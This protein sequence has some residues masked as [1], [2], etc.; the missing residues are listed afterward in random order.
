MSDVEM[1]NVA[2]TRAESAD[3]QHSTSPSAVSHREKTQIYRDAGLSL[4]KV[5]L[6]SDALSKLAEIYKIQYGKTLNVKSIDPV[7][8]GDL[9]SCCINICYNQ[10]GTRKML[11]KT[12]PAKIWAARTPAGQM[13]YRYHQMAK[14]TKERPDAAAMEPVFNSRN[15]NH[16]PLFPNIRQDIPDFLLTEISTET[17]VS[18]WDGPDSLD[19]EDDLPECEWATVEI[20]LLRDVKFVDNQIRQWNKLTSTPKTRKGRKLKP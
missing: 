17:D 2:V 5:Y 4:K 3:R 18:C 7:L 9:L 10:S 11:P 20:Q 16:K 12:A 1:K 13:L 15:K 8:L 6:G 14:G 19:N